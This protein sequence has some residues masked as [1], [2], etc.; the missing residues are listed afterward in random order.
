M[1]LPYLPRGSRSEVVKDRP[2]HGKRIFAWRGVQNIFRTLGERRV[3][4]TVDEGGAGLVFPHN[5]SVG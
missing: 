4:H 5:V 2:M 3:L 1:V